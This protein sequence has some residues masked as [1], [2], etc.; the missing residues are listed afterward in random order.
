MLPAELLTVDSLVVDYPG[1]GFRGRPTRVLD[2]VSLT[3]RRG[4]TLGLVGESGSGKTT[5]G[6]SL[7]GLA[8][9][10]AGT[11]AF[12]GRNISHPTRRQRRAL[13]SE[14]QVVF[15]D[16]YTSLNPAME[17]GAILA[18]PLVVQGVRGRRRV[19]A[20]PSSWTRWASPRTPRGGCRAT[21]RAVSA[22]GWP[23]RG[24]SRCDRSSSSATSR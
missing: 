4:E 8:P 2:D 22:S 15:Q 11:I 18:E 5:L 10:T 9:V 1:R 16:P 23:S 17:V 3:I 7:L 14:I 20:S 13:S 24:R 19:P 6:R 12:E 21:S